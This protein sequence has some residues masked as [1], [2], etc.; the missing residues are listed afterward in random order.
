MIEI[1]E[2]AQII[3]KNTDENKTMISEIIRILKKNML[4]ESKG[5]TVS[6]HAGKLERFVANAAEYVKSEQSAQLKAFKNKRK[7]KRRKSKTKRR[8]KISKRSKRR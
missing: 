7:T 1:N 4:K 2:R 3:N 8:R 5:T 6:D